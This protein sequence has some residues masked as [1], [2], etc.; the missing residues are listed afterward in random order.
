MVQEDML[1]TP[2][3]EYPATVFE[4]GHVRIYVDPILSERLE[5]GGSDIVTKSAPGIPGMHMERTFPYAGVFEARTRAAGLHRWYDVWFD[6]DTPLTKAA[7]SLDDVPGVME[8]EYRPVTMKAYDE[9]VT[10]A[11]AS[12]KAIPEGFPFDDPQFN[13][14]WDMYNDGSMAKSEKGCDVNVVPLWKTGVVGNSD[15]IVCVV[16]TGVDFDHEDLAPNIWSD[17]KRPD[18]HGWNF[19]DKSSNIIKGEHGTHVAGT[20]AAVNNNGTGVCG[21]AGGDYAKG[22]P[23]VKIISAQIFKDGEK[24]GG[25]GAEA[26]KWGADHG[27]VISQNSWG[28][29]EI[30]YVPASDRGAIDYFNTYAG[31]DENGNQVGPM[32]GGLVVFAAG[33]E[34]KDFGA[35]AFYE[36]ALAVGSVGSDF[37][38]AYYSCFGDWVDVA[39][40]GGDAQK[41]FQILSTLPDNRYGQ[42]QGT[43]MACPHVSGVAALIVSKLGG[44]GFT[45]DMLW[46]RIVNTAN[47]KTMKQNRNFPVGPLVDAEMALLAGGS[48]APDKVTDLQA[49][50]IRSNIV[51]FSLTVPGDEDDGKAYGINLYYS[52]KPITDLTLVPHSLIAVGDL[53]A[54]DRLE[55]IVELGFNTTYYLACTAMDRIGNR[56]ELSNQVSITTGEN[57]PPKVETSDPLKFTLKSHETRIL[58]F[59][60][61]DIDG[62]GVHAKLDK[63]SPADSLQFA[64]NM[65]QTVEVDALRAE[66]GTYTSLLHVLDDYDL[67][68]PLSYTY[69][70]LPNHGPK[71]IKDLDDM[72]FGAKGELQEVDL[73][74]VFTDED[75]EV[76]SFTTESSDNEI[77]NLHYREGKLFVTALKFGYASGK[78][79]ATDARGESVS[80][81]F[82]TLAR[83]G[84]EPIDIYPTTVTD[85][86]LLIRT[87]EDAQVKIEIVNEAGARVIDSS[88]NASPFSPG[89]VNLDKLGG[90]P[91]TV[92]ASWNGKT[93]TQNIVKL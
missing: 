78:V 73:G 77:L 8:V 22:I 63:G 47:D 57:H 21:I 51:S 58:T 86:N 69:T 56:S 61:S 32:A 3:G 44:Q 27:A 79:T 49:N 74:N 26:I 90:G 48:I 41:G 24:G 23:G 89:I 50:L 70:I 31:F 84:K 16:D 88:V 10:Y 65:V 5:E 11:S 29:D 82:S 67:E 30:D 52:D 13:K 9:T 40:P 34:N 91:Y 72:V 36:G 14:Q 37:V 68:T 2:Y 64:K 39:A 1:K 81:S 12:P 76:L 62:H 28:Y 42:M 92:K 93:A 71:L 19:F 80:S 87:A 17:P 4:K 33:N 18:V 38:R 66:P 46:S 45:R 55:D 54:G 7:M 59:T 25:H 75:G 83:D 20:I 53:E 60:Y 35:P 43:S 85:N 6:E 15:V